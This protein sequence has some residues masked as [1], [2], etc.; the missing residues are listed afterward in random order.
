MAHLSLRELYVVATVHIIQPVSQDQTNN[1]NILL[2]FF[3][4]SKQYQNKTISRFYLPTTNRRETLN[5]EFPQYQKALNILIPK[6]IQQHI[7][8]QINLESYFLY[9]FIYYCF[10]FFKYQELMAGEFSLHRGRRWGETDSLVNKNV[11]ESEN[12]Y[13]IRKNI[14]EFI[15]RLAFIGKRS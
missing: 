2:R 9:L 15:Q 13:L 3:F 1:N 10:V 6:Q 11:N 4:I 7:Y 12:I 5:T 8:F 14:Q